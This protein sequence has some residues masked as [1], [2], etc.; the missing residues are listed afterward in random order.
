MVGAEEFFAM[1]EMT[2]EF[3]ESLVTAEDIAE[4]VQGGFSQGGVS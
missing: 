1:A 3:G 4:M 2:L